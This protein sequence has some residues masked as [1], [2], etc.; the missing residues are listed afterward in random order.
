MRQS[1]VAFERISCISFSRCSHLEIWCI[2]SSWLRIWQSHVLCLGV[3]CGV[4]KNE[5]FGRFYGYSCAM[6]GSLL[7]EMHTL[8]TAKRTR[9]LRCFFFVLTQN[10]EVCP[11]D[12]S[13]A[14]KSGTLCTSCTW[15]AGCM[16]KSRG[17]GSVHFQLVSGTALH[18]FVMWTCT[19][20]K[21]TDR[22]NNNNSNN[23]QAVYPKSAFVRVTCCEWT[24][25]ST[26]FLELHSDVGS[27]GSAPCCGMSG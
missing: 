8:S 25:A 18:A 13:G 21:C 19:H 15:L 11:V 9:I 7:D 3:A 16:M 24:L 5:F 1:T 6:L 14:L 4:L 17:W 26:P 10:G 2:I 27:D 23:N 20:T 12:A 22:S